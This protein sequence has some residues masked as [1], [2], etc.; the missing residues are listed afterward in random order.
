MVR[1]VVAGEG[2][3]EPSARV[4]P[5]QS[6]HMFELPVYEQRLEA[7]LVDLALNRRAFR[8]RVQP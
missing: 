1:Q 8:S 4:S 7:L 2:G 3:M 6:K 5:A